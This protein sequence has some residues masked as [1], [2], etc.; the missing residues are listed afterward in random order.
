MKKI[1]LFFI[2]A[3][4]LALTLTAC[5]PSKPADLVGTTWKMTA[6]GELTNQTP[7][8]AG[9]ETSLTFTKDGKLSGNMGCNSMGGEYSISG[10]T[11]TFNNVYATEMACPDP[12]M[13]QEGEAFV[14][15]Q[16]NTTYKIDGGTLTITS[17][18]GNDTLT[19]TAAASK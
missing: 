9:I 12:Q 16:G 19:F 17:T 15:L 8:I 11:I 18:D 5:A 14:V 10:Q 13:E 6:Q 2:I 3:A 4:A 7:A 1:F